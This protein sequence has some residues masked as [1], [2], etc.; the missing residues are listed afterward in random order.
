MLKNLLIFSS[1]VVE[2]SAVNRLVV[3]SSPTWGVN[4]YK[5]LTK[6][7]DFFAPKEIEI[8]DYAT[9]IMHLRSLYISLC[10]TTILKIKD[11]NV[12]F[13]LP[14]FYATFL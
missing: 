7:N 11:F 13:A 4:T 6:F 14:T 10:K 2:R 9:C 1:S 5:K 12:L 3:G 8:F